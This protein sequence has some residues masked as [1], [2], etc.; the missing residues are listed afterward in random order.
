MIARSLPQ[1]SCQSKFAIGESGASNCSTSTE[2]WTLRP[3][4]SLPG[5]C[6]PGLLCDRERGVRDDPIEMTVGIWRAHVRLAAASSAVGRSA[7]D[8]PLGRPIRTIG[9][10]VKETAVEKEPAPNHHRLARRPV[11]NDRIQLI[12]PA[13]PFRNS[14]ET[15]S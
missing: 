8:S 7:Q 9:L 5:W 2:L 10:A 15:L 13:S 11:L 4:R 14:R 3:S 6:A 12:G 1:P